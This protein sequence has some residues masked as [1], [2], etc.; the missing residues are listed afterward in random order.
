[1]INT[2]ILSFFYFITIVLLIVFVAVWF[3][4]ADATKD[5]YLPENGHIK[6]EWIVDAWVQRQEIKAVLPHG[7]CEQG[8]YKTEYA[9]KS[10]VWYWSQ[11]PIYWMQQEHGKYWCI[12][13]SEK[14]N[15]EAKEQ[16]SFA[17]GCYSL[18]SIFIEYGEAKK[19]PSYGGC[20]VLWH[21]LGHSKHMTHTEM[22]E[23][24]PNDE[25]KSP[26]D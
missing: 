2:R 19:T 17:N 23:K 24:W 4:G 21:E 12:N 6:A 26:R 22:K 3:V 16:A 18:N 11:I 25:C 5:L 15:K 13:E 1:M 20:N 14:H 10:N 7:G 9:C 8:F